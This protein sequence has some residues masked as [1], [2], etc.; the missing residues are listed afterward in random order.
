MT[1]PPL[2][3]SRVGRVLEGAS[4]LCPQGLGAYCRGGEIVLSLRC[5]QTYAQMAESVDALVSNTNGRK[6]VPVRARLWVQH[7]R[8]R[9]TTRSAV[10]WGAPFV[11]ARGGWAA[12]AAL[13]RRHLEAQRAL[14]APIEG[15]ADGLLL[16]G[17]RGDEA[18]AELLPQREEGIAAP[19]ARAYA[20]GASAPVA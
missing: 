13:V 1:S 20:A 18:R 16:C 19:L 8:E 7:I 2:A 14:G 4:Q 5:R 11:L 15:I 3:V 17:E 6:F 10:W 12:L 9:P